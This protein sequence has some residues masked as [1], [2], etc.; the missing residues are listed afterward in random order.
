M[1][2]LKEYATNIVIISVLAT[3][4]EIIIPEGKNKKAASVVIGLVVMLTVMEPIAHI[5]EITQNHNFP[6]FTIEES[7]KNY[8][9]S[10]VSDVFEENLATAIKEKV[11]EKFEKDIDCKVSTA[12]NEHGEITEIESVEISSSD[13]A[14]IS[15][16]KT[17]FSLSEITVKGDANG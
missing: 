5:T 13:D 9:K 4:F 10:L 2:Y 8:D 11:S 17:E 16:I 3:I 15:F 1:T 6:T 12:R 14:V 7:Y